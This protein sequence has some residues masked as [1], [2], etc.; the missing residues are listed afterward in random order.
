MGGIPK[1]RHARHARRDLFEQL[2]PFAADAVFEIHETGGVAAR[3][4]QTVDVAG[5]DRI[6]DDRE[7]DR[8]GAGRLQ[9]RPQGRRATGQDDVGR[10]RGQ[11]R[12][13]SANFGGIGRGP[14]G[15]DLQV[16]ADA[17]AQ[18]PQAL[19]ECPD[20]GLP[21][22]IVRSC[23]YEYADAPHPLALLRT[24]GER[25]CRHAAKKR[26]EL[27]P[28]HC[29][30]RLRTGQRIVSNQHTEIGS[31]CPLWV[32]SRHLRCNKSCPLCPRKQKSGGSQCAIGVPRYGVFETVVTPKQLAANNKGW[33][34][35]DV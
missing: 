2:Q 12:R 10:E 3:P 13:L 25:P 28:S 21:C 17:P 24:R 19:Q 26:D 1:D 32:K 14:A 16:A 4:R 33:R 7:H 31:P 35:K 22:R 34:A 15:V 5:A 20:A 27:A 9:Q 11:F 30:P 29:P 23:G 18:L 6:E 8:D